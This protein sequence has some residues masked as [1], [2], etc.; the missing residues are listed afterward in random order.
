M[1]EALQLMPGSRLREELESSGAGKVSRCYQCATCTSVCE[2]STPQNA[3]PRKQMLLAQWGLVD[4]LASDPAVWLCHQCADCSERCPRDAK[5]GDVLKGMR[6]EVIRTLSFPK[7]AGSL[8]ANARVTWPLMILLPW[9]F[10][11]ILL[12]AMGYYPV[13]AEQLLNP[14]EHGGYA[15]I[16]PH[17]LLYA[18]YFPI[19]GWVTLAAGISGAKLWKMMGRG[20]NRRGSF[21]SGLMAVMMDVATHK[22]FGECTAKPSRRTPHLLLFWGFAGAAITSGLLIVAIYIQHLPMPLPLWH[23][24]KLLGNISAVLLVIGGIQLLVNRYGSGRALVSSNAFDNFFLGL[25][26]AVIF[27]GVVTEAVRLASMPA[28]AFVVYTLHLGVVMALFLTF[29]YSKFAHMLYR[30]LAQV[31]HRLMA[32]PERE[33]A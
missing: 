20:V 13:N 12:F 10:W 1:A 17:W 16:V 33:Q 3:F 7:F 18:I 21:I 14:G 6:A 28:T 4:Q 9:L 22:S 30:V 19:A 26:A 23:P 27:T 29:P 32:E 2:L 11:V 5:P 25:V 15:A 24:Y 31:H 8:V